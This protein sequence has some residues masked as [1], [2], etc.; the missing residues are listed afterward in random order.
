MWELLLPLYF[1]GPFDPSL[2]KEM[3]AQTYFHYETHTTRSASTIRTTTSA[4]GW[5]RSGCRPS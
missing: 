4:R 1:E 3:A 2:P 5:A